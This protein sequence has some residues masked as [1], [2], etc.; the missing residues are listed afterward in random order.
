MTPGA[1]RGWAGAA[2]S[3]RWRRPGCWRARPGVALLAAGTDGRDGPTDAAGAI[4]DGGPGPPSRRGRD[5]ARDLAAHDAYRALD[6]A[7]A[8]LRAGL[9]GTN[10]MD[11]VIGIC[12]AGK[13][14][15]ERERTSV[16][17]EQDNASG[18]GGLSRLRFSSPLRRFSLVLT[19][20]APSLGLK[21]SPR[22]TL[23]VHPPERVGLDHHLPRSQRPS[24]VAGPARIAPAHEDPGRI[25]QRIGVAEKH[26]VQSL[27]PQHPGGGPGR[28][29]PPGPVQHLDLHPTRW[30]GRKAA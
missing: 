15:R 6:A 5:P 21:S 11:I 22:M 1:P 17:G 7:G 23:T 8:L 12:G 24:H 29:L 18:L 14:E 10:V 9:T 2:R 25:R 26:H 20:A 16:S 13:K 30:A 3:W 27:T 19:D 28:S 4:V